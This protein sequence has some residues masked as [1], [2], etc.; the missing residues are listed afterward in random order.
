MDIKW[1]TLSLSFFL[2]ACGGGGDG[3]SPPTNKTIT[4]EEQGESAGSA[5][6]IENTLAVQ[7]TTQ[8]LSIPDGFSFNPVVEYTFDVDISGYSTQR[9]YVSI[10]GNYVPLQDGSFVPNF[11]SRIT[12]SSLDNGK[13]ALEFIISDSQSSVLAEIW[14]YD[15]SD[16][17]Q[18]QFTPSQNSWIW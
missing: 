5:G 12:S 3:G 9:A 13:A 8:D 10:Y 6:F 1:I 4:T 14:F 2:L 15:G 7:R 16:P 11:N 18:Y 17:I